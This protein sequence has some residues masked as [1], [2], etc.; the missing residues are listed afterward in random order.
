MRLKHLILAFGLTLGATF[1]AADQPPLPRVH[2]QIVEVQTDPSVLAEQIRGALPGSTFTERGEGWL[3]IDYVGPLPATLP[4]FMTTNLPSMSLPSLPVG[5]LTVLSFAVVPQETGSRLHL[6]AQ[7]DYDASGTDLFK[8]IFG[9]PLPRRTNLLSQE[10][11]ADTCMNL[12]VYQDYRS[13]DRVSRQMGRLLR[14]Q[15]MPHSSTSDSSGTLFLAENADCAVFVHI[16]PDRDFP[17]QSMV[18]VR[19]ME[20]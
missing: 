7:S 3:Y 2:T 9:R 13:A 17:T 10:G 4:D 12:L 11:I 19:L 5:A 1:A 16:E 8:V 20:K 6:R 14:A 18:V 15:G